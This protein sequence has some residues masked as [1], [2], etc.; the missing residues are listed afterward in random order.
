MTNHQPCPWCSEVN[1]VTDAATYPIYC[2]S[3]GHRVDV[4]R[5]QCDCRK[6]AEKARL[7]RI[8]DSE[9]EAKKD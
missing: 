3:C 9:R 2:R 5:A 6:C 7:M 1:D 4:E 8:R